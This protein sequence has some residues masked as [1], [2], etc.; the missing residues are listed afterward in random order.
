VKKREKLTLTIENFESL[1][2]KQ[3]SCTKKIFCPSNEF[4]KKNS[5]R[6]N[7]SKSNLYCAKAP[8]TTHSKPQ[9][10]TETNNMV[11]SPVPHIGKAVP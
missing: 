10:Y 3:R 7:N 9:L 8:G 6:T 11:H 5:F 4:K 1:P 2:Y